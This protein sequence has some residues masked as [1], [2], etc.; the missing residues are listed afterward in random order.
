MRFLYFLYFLYF[1]RFGEVLECPRRTTTTRTES[2][3]TASQRTRIRERRPLGWRLPRALGRRHA[4]LALT[5]QP[6][7]EEEEEEDARRW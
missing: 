5:C 6:A 7:A 3:R 4:P 1:V 2:R